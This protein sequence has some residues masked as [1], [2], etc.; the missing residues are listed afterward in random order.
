MIKQN[1]KHIYYEPSDAD[2]SFATITRNFKF[3]NSSHCNRYCK[4]MF[5]VP[6]SQI[7]KKYL[8]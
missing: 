7:Y 4:A 2:K 8:I 5:G 6:L 3:V 1:L